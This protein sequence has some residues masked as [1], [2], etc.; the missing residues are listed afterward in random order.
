MHF[1]KSVHFFKFISFIQFLTDSYLWLLS[2]L[3]MCAVVM[4]SDFY[5][6]LLADSGGLFSTMIIHD[7][8][9]YSPN[10]TTGCERPTNSLTD[11]VFFVF[12]FV[13]LF[14]SFCAETK[15]VWPTFCHFLYQQLTFILKILKNMKVGWFSFKT[16]AG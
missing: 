11:I 3:W 13:C 15:C 6:V 12:L 9:V 7:R 1:H 10:K 2:S 4:F 8:E 16:E 14:V 5:V